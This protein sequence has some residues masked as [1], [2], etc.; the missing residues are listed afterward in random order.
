VQMKRDCMRRLVDAFAT[1]WEWTRRLVQR[2]FN[3]Y[4]TASGSGLMSCCRTATASRCGMSRGDVT[5]D[6]TSIT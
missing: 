2:P 4:V 6:T 3:S 5:S 1:L